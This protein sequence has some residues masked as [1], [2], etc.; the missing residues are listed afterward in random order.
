M[1]IK[2]LSVRQDKVCNNFRFV[3]VWKLL[4]CLI[5]CYSCVKYS[6]STSKH[7]RFEFPN[8]GA[9]MYVH[10]TAHS[11]KAGKPWSIAVL[12][13]GL[14]AKVPSPILLKSPQKNVASTNAPGALTCIQAYVVL[15]FIYLFKEIRKRIVYYMSWSRTSYKKLWLITCPSFSNS[16]SSSLLGWTY[17]F[18]DSCS[19]Y[20]RDHDYEKRG[21]DSGLTNTYV[22]FFKFIFL[23]LFMTSQPTQKNTNGPFKDSTCK[24][25]LSNNT[26][27]FH[28][29]F[30]SDVMY[31]LVHC[32][33]VNIIK[34]LCSPALVIPFLNIKKV[35]VLVVPM[36]R[37]R[38]SCFMS[39][40]KNTGSG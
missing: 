16:L 10:W 26:C 24:P 1:S 36:P 14:G 38:A 13:G 34:A 11:G 25:V 17:G 21:P 27:I 29:I 18:M 28:V 33:Q 35:Q 6:R 40:K 19:R 2:M 15:L 9:Y 8:F 3:F 5:P 31:K 20:R 23:V 7:P 4:N 12:E 30:Q 37:P 32:L 22:V 39:W